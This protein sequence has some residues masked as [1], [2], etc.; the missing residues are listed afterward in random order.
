MNPFRIGDRFQYIDACKNELD[1]NQVATIVDIDG[2]II[3][4]IFNKKKIWL[5]YTRIEL[6]EKAED[7]SFNKQTKEILE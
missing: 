2:P 6:V 4:H 3:Y 7:V 5:D 1:Y